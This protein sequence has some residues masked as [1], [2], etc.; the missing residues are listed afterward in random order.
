M[1]LKYKINGTLAVLFKK[2]VVLVD[3]ACRCLLVPKLFEH[4]ICV[5]LQSIKTNNKY[6][7]PILLAQTQRAEMVLCSRFIFTFISPRDRELIVVRKLCIRWFIKV[8]ARIIGKQ[9]SKP[10]SVKIIH[11]ADICRSKPRQ[12]YL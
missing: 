3:V 4:A 11:N 7:N 1:K 8:L 12:I 5:L 6:L 10:R 2:M 9:R